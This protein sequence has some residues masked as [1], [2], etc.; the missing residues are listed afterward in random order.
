MGQIL[1]TLSILCASVQLVV[2]YNDA[3]AIAVPVEGIQID[4]DLSDWP[5]DLP[6][7]RIRMNTNAY[8]PTDLTGTRLDSSADFSPHFRVGY[9]VQEQLVYVAL[10][11]RD[12][13]L[14]DGDGCEI[15]WYA[16]PDSDIPDIGDRPIVVKPSSDE[17]VF[18]FLEGARYK[19]G[20]DQAWSRV[21][22]PDEKWTRV[23]SDYIKG[24]FQFI[25]YF[26]AEQ[27]T[28]VYSFAF[29]EDDFIEAV[30]QL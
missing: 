17:G 28:A 3:I 5:K 2:A 27:A 19:Y 24:L 9:S 13:S 1:L 15:Y 12:D 10:E 14:T 23:G 4:G 26:E 6:M 18:Y 21:D 7:Y 20:D 16:Q 29:S 8:G 22:F 11:V 30:G 25:R